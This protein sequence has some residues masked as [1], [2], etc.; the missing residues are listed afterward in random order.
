M[1]WLGRHRRVLVVLLIAE[2]GGVAFVG[3]SGNGAASSF[4]V[5]PANDLNQLVSLVGIPAPK[6]APL[7]DNAQPPLAPVPPAVCGPDS[8]PLSGEQGR[9]PPAAINSPAAKQGWTCN[10]SV[11]GHY[12]GTPGGF[13]VWRYI[14]QAGHQ[15]AFYDSSLRS[16]L[17]LVS[18]A[19][20]PSPGVVVLDMSNPTH[21]VRT[22]LLTSLP[23]LMPH[24]SLNL[25]S[26]RGLLAAELGNGTTLPGLMAIYDVSKDCLH[27]SLDSTYLAAPFGHESGFAPDGRTFYIGGGEGIAAVDVNNPKHPHTLWQGAVYAHGLNV[28]DDGDTLYDADPINGN[29]VLLNVSQI[30][31]RKHHPVV[32]EISRLTW[33]TVSVPQNT[34]PM[35]I[36]GHRYLLEFDEFGFRFTT[37]APPDQVGA[38]RIIN[39]DNPAHPFVVS[40][41]RL[42]VNMPAQ[43]HQADGDPTQVP[44]R[45]FSYAAHYCAI[46]REVDPEIAACSFINSGLRIFNIQDPLHPR[47]VAYY[48][49]PPKA[50]G[51]APASD[52]AL[53]MPA[54]D[55]ATRQVWYTDAASGFY[56]L[57]LDAGVWPHPLTIP[58]GCPAPTG[59]LSGRRLG[60]V[61]LGQRRALVRHDLGRFST[62][63]RRSFDYFCFRGGGIRVGYPSAR[64]LRSMRRSERRRYGGRAVIALTANR[65]YALD[66]VRAGSALAGIAR[67]LHVGRGYR[68]GQNTWYVVRRRG[69]NG[70]LKV[71]HGVIE[72]IGITVSSLTTGR[73]AR[74]FLGSFG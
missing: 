71:R 30:Q 59:S 42:A 14:D 39:I 48:I 27:P 44:G 72:E 8:R 1:R 46:P 64:L 36:G 74:S 51:A 73:R 23:M 25:N 65:T 38:A 53:S 12:G 17:N 34:A 3:L 35:T 5:L 11:V 54:F 10:L 41:L 69:A 70:V 13:R 56:A 40:N 63:G 28:S 32:T 18:V 52:F 19:A 31:A 37:L 26:S 60:P 67:R 49:S 15:C 9:V 2:L 68:I 21:P 58:T 50:E 7:Q 45:T 4:P 33:D 62:R 47:E 20:G 43:H 16:P 55:P 6:P 29:L 24:E 61:S 22:D 66:G 57:K